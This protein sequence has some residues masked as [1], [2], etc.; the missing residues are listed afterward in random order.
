MRARRAEDHIVVLR[1]E[2]DR[3]RKMYEEERH[4]RT[5]QLEAIRYLWKEVQSLQSWKSEV[6]T[7]QQFRTMDSNRQDD[8]YNYSEEIQQTLERMET[9]NKTGASGRDSGY[10]MVDVE[11][12]RD[13]EKTCAS[14]QNQVAQ[15][16]QALQS[17]SS[18]VFQSGFL[19]P[20]MDTTDM[21]GSLLV[22]GYEDDE[23]SSCDESNYTTTKWGCVPHSLS[24]YPSEEEEQYFLTV[25]QS[26]FPTP[27]RNLR[28]EHKGENSVVISWQASRILDGHNR[29]IHKPL[30]GYRVYVEEKPL[31]LISQ[32]GLKALI[33]GLNPK[34]TYKIYVRAVS[35]LGESNT[36]GKE[37]SASD[38][39]NMKERD[40]PSSRSERP[41]S[42][43]S[44]TNSDGILMQPKLHTHRR[45]RS[46]DLQNNV[47]DVEGDR[48][49]A[50]D[51]SSQ[52][53][54]RPAESPRSPQAG[55]GVKGTSA[56]ISSSKM[57]ETFTIDTSGS[58]LQ[59]INEAKGALG[60]SDNSEGS[61]K[62]H[63]RKRSKDFN[64]SESSSHVKTH[65]RTRSKDYEW[66]K[67]IEYAGSNLKEKDH[68]KAWVKDA[69]S[70][71]VHG[72]P[73]IDAR[74]RHPSGSRPSS[75]APSD[76]SEKSQPER[77]RA[78]VADM[79]EKFS[80]KSVS[81]FGGSLGANDNEP[82]FTSALPPR[83][84]RTGSHEDI[85]GESRR[86]PTKNMSP[87]YTER[88][89]TPSNGSESDLS[90]IST[91][92]AARQIDM[93]RKGTGGT[94]GIVSKLLQKL[95]NFSKSQEENLHQRTQ[96]I[97]K[98]STDSSGGEDG[99]P[100]I[101]RQRKKSES[102]SEPVSMSERQITNSDSSSQSDDPQL[103]KKPYKTH[104]RSGSDQRVHI[105]HS[106]APT[107]P[108][109][110]S[111][112]QTTESTY[113]HKPQNLPSPNITI[114]DYV[115][116]HP[117]YT[118]RPEP[119]RPTSGSSPSQYSPDYTSRPQSNPELTY[120]QP[121][122]SNPDFTPRPESSNVKRT[123]SFHG[124]HRQPEVTTPR[125]SGSEE[126]LYNR[127]VNQQSNPMPSQQ[128][129]LS[130]MFT[131]KNRKPQ[132]GSGNIHHIPILSGAQLQKQSK[133]PPS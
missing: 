83:Q 128:P 102:E 37:S 80:G 9:M 41:S 73:I 93:D 48:N 91:S 118:P 106:S 11:R 63:R 12:H 55:S 49:V 25:P 4:L 18:V 60:L 119:H 123:A 23:I 100:V 90:E 20:T 129:F 108:S 31:A 21:E 107:T 28:L 10:A 45:T 112:N 3:Q 81:S 98:K 68:K 53:I 54:S 46:K 120:G 67:D 85:S 97:K 32:G 122:P 2:L 114:P 5:L 7:S 86:T 1:S 132:S 65:R 104:R 121:T 111:G 36:S 89:R 66:R 109:R 43:R 29:E 103:G 117:D 94:A 131:R 95:Q 51:R 24:P 101:R 57:S 13:L 77:K 34:A 115:P 74:K 105:R 124:S 72:I 92:S 70:G 8:S 33:H 130:G 42:S 82:V 16:S 22:T 71:E 75:P 69:P 64:V 40:R 6:L 47:L 52:S 125:R 44:N 113:T 79:L 76:I 15:L 14:L 78:T 61:V 133:N 30:V 38:Q 17:V 26:G 127:S 50:S 87:T 116:H 96:K 110:L 39:D 19:G 56:S 27:P 58:L 59:A 99:E 62:T 35:A 126:N 88:K 84:K